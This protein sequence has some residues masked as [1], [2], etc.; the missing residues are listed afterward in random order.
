MFATALPRHLR[1]AREHPVLALAAF[2]LAFGAQYWASLVLISDSLP[3]PPSAGPGEELSLAGLQATPRLVVLDGRGNLDVYIDR[4][5]LTPDSVDS[6]KEARGVTPPAGEGEV[7]WKTVAGSAPSALELRAVKGGA[8]PAQLSLSIPDDSEIQGVVKLDLTAD[9]PLQLSVYTALV[10]DQPVHQRLAVGESK[11]DLEAMSLSFVVPAGVAVRLVQTLEEGED[12]TR[13]VLGGLGEGP[14]APAGLAVGGIGQRRGGATAWTSYACAAPPGAWLWGGVRAL[15][16]G[17]CAAATDSLRALTVALKPGEA[18]LDLAGSGWRWADG[19]AASPSVMGRI[20][21]NPA[22]ASLLLA[23]D[24]A[25]ALWVMLALLNLRRQGRYRIF[26]SYRRTDAAGHAGRL[27]R[28]LKD[29]LGEKSTFLD[30][31]IPPGTPFGPLIVARIRAAEVVLAV[32]SQHWLAAADEKT[33]MRRLD[34]PDDWVRRELETALELGKRLVPVLVGGARMPAEAD[35]PASLKPLAGL[36]AELIEDAHFERDVEALAEALDR[37]GAGR[38][39][40]S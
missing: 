40:V 17:E 33:G 21:A 32:I 13:L 16:R 26:I 30:D 34:D 22:L 2:L 31:D 3:K 1:Q 28:C 14:G 15:A 7:V 8:A 39:A 4:A 37:P 25:L 24:G 19:Q 23:A 18:A 27:K 38:L 35:L 20:R 6:L 29:C 36:D 12:E 10:P 11:F 9:A 5:A